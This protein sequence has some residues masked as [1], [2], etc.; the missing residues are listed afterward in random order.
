MY[1]LRESF[2][3]KPLSIPSCPPPSFST[4]SFYFFYFFKKSNYST[5]VFLLVL[6]YDFV[7]IPVRMLSCNRN[8][9]FP[10]RP[11]RRSSEDYM[12][13]VQQAS[14]RLRGCATGFPKLD[15]YST[16]SPYSYSS[17][18]FN[19]FQTMNPHVLLLFIPLFSQHL[20]ISDNNI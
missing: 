5:F 3:D 11:N 13:Y 17:Y 4:H 6:V 7:L 14:V 8:Y 9:T 19:F 10:P 1:T 18:S 15:I 2:L 12:A 16:T 20:Q